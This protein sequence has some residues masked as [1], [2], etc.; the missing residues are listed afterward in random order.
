MFLCWSLILEAAVC[1][2]K[3]GAGFEAAAGAQV[4]VLAD[5]LLLCI[6]WISPQCGTR[7]SP[8]V[9][10]Q[11]YPRWTCKIILDPVEAKQ[12]WVGVPFVSLG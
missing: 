12:R 2:N 6:A 1:L 9:N 10:L 8:V 11:L 5:A 4:V 3:A 7:R